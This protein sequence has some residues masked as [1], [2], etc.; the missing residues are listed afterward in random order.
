MQNNSTEK[1]KQEALINQKDYLR[2]AMQVVLQDCIN[3]QFDEF[4]GVKS[5]ERAEGRKGYRNG[6]YERKL[7]TRVGTITLHVCRDREGEFS[8]KLFERYQRSEKALVAGLIE[9]YFKGVS[10][11]KV[12]DVVEELC[13]FKVS[14]SQVSELVKT[15][16]EELAEW[17][18]R[19]LSTIYM[20]LEVDA[21]YEKVREGGR[22]VSKAA[23]TVTGITEDGYREI[24]A[25]AI[26]NS[27]S[28][29]EWDNVFKDLIRRD[30]KGVKYIVS[31]EN[32][33]LVK[34]IEKNFQGVVRQRC[35]VHFMRNFTAKLSSSLK[36][37]GIKLLQNVFAADSKEDALELK[38]KLTGFLRSHKK[39]EIAAWIEDDIED[40]LAVY[41]LP[42]K[43]R[44]QMK[45]TNMIERFNQELKRR[46]RVIRIF[47][48]EESCLRMLTALCMEQSEAWANR[49]YLPAG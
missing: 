6:T 43:H 42:K 4:M 22:T 32:A 47:P 16:D 37:E 29:E 12:S 41:E 7:N 5:Y 49:R 13:G 3:K 38:T 39:E 20:Y 25:C 27:E 45:S 21:R 11:R 31:D 36:A 1:S 40:T 17:R 2:D 14:K 33:G 15:L 19:L 48:N 10:T 18:T 26:I 23:V 30:L 35:Q 8:P 24:I 46:T 9:M 34:A 28:F 44:K